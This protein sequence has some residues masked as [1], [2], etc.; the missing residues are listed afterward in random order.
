MLKVI[1]DDRFVCPQVFFF[2]FLKVYYYLE[3]LSFIPHLLIDIKF[4]LM[5]AFCE[6]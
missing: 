1:Y 4:V 2:F 3:Q 6:Q 5:T